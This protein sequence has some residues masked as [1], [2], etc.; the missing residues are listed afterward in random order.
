[1]ARTILEI[2]KSMTEQFMSDSVIRSKYGLKDGDSFDVKFSKV[3]FENILFFIVAAAI[4]VVES[5]FDQ[6]SAH[7][8]KRISEAV[9]ASI[10]WYHRIALEF[11]YGDELVLNEQTQEYGYAVTDESRRVVKYAAVRDNASGVNILV[12]G[13]ENGLPAALDDDVLTAFKYYLNK[14]KPAGVLMS[15]RSYDPDSLQME[16][17]VQYDPLV[18]NPE[19]SLILEP[20]VFPVEDAIKAYLAGIV[21]GGSFNKTRFVDAIQ[22]VSGVED[23]VVDEIRTKPVTRTD[24]VIAK[25]NNVTAVAGSFVFDSLNSVIDYVHTL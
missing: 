16:I 10:P 13:E 15:V 23:V 17:R 9:I 3:S 2:K 4:Y 12:S 25:G 11:Q 6:F 19:G 7:I 1:M 8:E 5:L 24:Y 22:A 21:Y 20:D 18:M 14:R